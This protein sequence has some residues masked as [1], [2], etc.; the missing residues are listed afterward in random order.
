MGIE[1]TRLLAGLAIAISV[2]AAACAADSFPMAGVLAPGLTGPVFHATTGW[3]PGNA[4]LRAL[5]EAGRPLCCL[6]V[7]PR[8]LAEASDL[9][10]G[11]AERGTRHDV[12]AEGMLARRLVEGPLLAPVLQSGVKVMR[13]DS[14]HSGLKKS[15]RHWTL[16][17]CVTQEGLR[18]TIASPDQPG[19]TVFYFPLGY[20]VEPTCR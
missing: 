16:D 14:E 13:S 6:R 18:L 12:T 17:R 20:D 4:R 15:D 1:M 2:S 7:N 3:H 11:D 9:R 19:K 8:P 5:D 10:S